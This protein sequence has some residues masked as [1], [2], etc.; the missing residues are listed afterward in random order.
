MS[1]KVSQIV[2]T[3]PDIGKTMEM[4]VQQNNVGA[5]AWRRTGV[6]TFDGNANLK[7][8]VTYE[9]IRLHLEKV[10]KRHFSYGTVVQLCVSRNRRRKSSQ[11]YKA[12]AKITTR[13]A[14]KGFSLRFNPDVHWSASFYKGLNKLQYVDGRNIL[15][16]N[17]DDATGFRLDTLTTCKQFA[18][19]TVHGKNILQEQIM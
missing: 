9:K 14:R 2:S 8:K 5:D 16:L 17:R 11:R 19:P 12:V 13:R 3:C 15:N 18:T 1:K 4:F 6:L 10:Y 7:N